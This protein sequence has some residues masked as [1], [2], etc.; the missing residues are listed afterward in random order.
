MAEVVIYTNRGCHYCVMAKH[1]LDSK[2]V[3]YIE[4]KLGKSRS[5]DQ[6]FAVMT[7]NAKK[8][9]QIFIAGEWIGGYEELLKY[10][11]AGELNWRLGLEDKPKVGFVQKI[12]RL[13]K[14]EKY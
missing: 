4:K 10:D 14:G 3:Q 9:P 7:N 13:F 5:R 12:A 1:Y 11:N 8:I 2:K 6:E